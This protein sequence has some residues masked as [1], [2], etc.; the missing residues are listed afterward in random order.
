A[1]PDQST[2]GML[3]VIAQTFWKVDLLLEA[4]SHDFLPPPK[5]ASRVLVFQRLEGDL[6]EARAYLKWVKAAFLHPRKLLAS[7]MA[8]ANSRISKSQVS[9]W[10]QQKG[11]SEK[12]RPG[13]LFVK[14][15]IDFFQSFQ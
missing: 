13:E 6:P 7:N 14:D 4:S 2:Y 12:A 5:V 9:D 10:L 1:T 8:E 15:Y 3:S 11:F